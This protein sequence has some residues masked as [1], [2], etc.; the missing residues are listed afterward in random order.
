MNIYDKIEAMFN[1]ANENLNEEML[2]KVLDELSEIKQIL[3]LT[4]KEY[5]KEYKKTLPDDYFDFVNRFR[6]EMKEDKINN[7]Y[8]EM[9]FEGMRLGVNER[10]L[11]YDKDTNRV[12]PKYKAFEIYEKLYKHYTINKKY[13]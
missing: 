4:P 10:G 6:E 2:Q 13:E 12:I 9:L 11:L 8:P 3:K 7:V 1:D 5:K